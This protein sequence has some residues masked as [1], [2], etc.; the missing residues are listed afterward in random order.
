MHAPPVTQTYLRTETESKQGRRI[1]FV[2]EAT[3]AKDAVTDISQWPRK[4]AM[5]KHAAAMGVKPEDIAGVE[6]TWRFF[7]VE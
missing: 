6:V 1:L 7:T 5:A 4:T 2:D 3:E